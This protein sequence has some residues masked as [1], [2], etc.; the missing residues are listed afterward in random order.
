VLETRREFRRTPPAHLNWSR[1]QLWGTA[2][3]LGAQRDYAFGSGVYTIGY[4]ICVSNNTIHFKKS[5]GS[6]SPAGS[7]AKN[8]FHTPHPEEAI[9]A[10]H[11][12]SGRRIR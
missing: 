1:P 10:R 8:H 5:I 2:I 6:W 7:G 9:S 3:S 12:V 4:D 11:K